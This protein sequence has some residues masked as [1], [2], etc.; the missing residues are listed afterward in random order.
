MTT[1]YEN[2]RK[3]VTGDI[4]VKCKFKLMSRCSLLHLQNLW[5]ALV[6][7]KRRRRLKLRIRELPLQMKGPHTK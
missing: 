2:L 4:T 6:P 3:I 7:A 5:R 1:N